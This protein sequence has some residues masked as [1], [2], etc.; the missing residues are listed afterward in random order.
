VHHGRY[1]LGTKWT[2]TFERVVL[3]RGIDG[4]LHVPEVNR[5]CSSDPLS[6]KGPVAHTKEWSLC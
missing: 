6:T 5:P 2:A 3:E 4:E 1:R